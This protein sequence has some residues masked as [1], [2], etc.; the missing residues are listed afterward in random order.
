MAHR[1][2]GG[3]PATK[4]LDSAGVAFKLHSYRHDPSV[5]S[6]GVESASQ[7]GVS[8]AR[9]FKTLVVDAG[10]S[11]AVGVVPVSQ[12]LDL[13]AL[14]R[15]LGVKRVELADPADA[16]RSSG[17]VVGGISPLGQRRRLP[18]VVDQSILD[19]ESVFV[20]AGARGLSAELAPHAMLEILDARLA[21]ISR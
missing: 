15:V 4:L 1:S 3:T 7:L 14:A 18:T 16:E 2:T 19:H 10:K 12:Q 21:R 9:V 6:F 5:T 8:P 11:L 13:K 17:M 20:S